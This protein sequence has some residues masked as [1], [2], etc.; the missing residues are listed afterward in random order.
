MI[1]GKKTVIIVGFLSRY[2]NIRVQAS[3]FEEES[4]KIMPPRTA[5]EVELAQPSFI[6]IYQRA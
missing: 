3:L 5:V 1:L 2:A 4:F 6:R